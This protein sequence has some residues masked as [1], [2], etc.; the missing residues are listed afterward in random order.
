MRV[1][2]GPV[3][4]RRSKVQRWVIAR[5]AGRIDSIRPLIAAGDAA[6]Y[7]ELILG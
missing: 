7:L 5:T 4:G 2:A 6:L 1:R 3:A